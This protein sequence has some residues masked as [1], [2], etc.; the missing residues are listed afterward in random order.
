MKPVATMQFGGSRPAKLSQFGE[1]KSF[2]PSPI[3]LQ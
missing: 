3:A 2:H 1:N